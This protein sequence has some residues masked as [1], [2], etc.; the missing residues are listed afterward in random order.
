MPH[1]SA[2]LSCYFWK[3]ATVSHFRLIY[4]CLLFHLIIYHSDQ[5]KLWLIAIWSI[6]SHIT[7][8]KHINACQ[9][10]LIKV[11]LG[12]VSYYH[13]SAYIFAHFDHQRYHLKIVIQIP[14]HAS[15]G[16]SVLT[17]SNF[18]SNLPKR[19]D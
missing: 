3:I 17:F 11:L 2:L 16:F 14:Q 18:C 13:V 6:H 1:C 4:F 12:H 19:F 5:F 15:L 10:R 8:T 9:G 7:S